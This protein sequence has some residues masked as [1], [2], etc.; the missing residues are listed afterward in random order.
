[1]NAQRS[2]IISCTTTKNRI[3]LLFYMIESL[4]KQAL[5]PDMV[6]VNISSAPSLA[7]EGIARL[8]AWLDKEF[9]KI[10]RVKDMGPYTKLLPVIEMVED[11]D[12]IVTADDDILYHPTWLQ[13]LVE[14]ADT[15]PDHIICARA[16]NIKKNIFGKWQGY[17]NW[18]RI[19]RTKEGMSILPTG[20]GGVVYR[21]ALLD[22]EFLMDLTAQDIAPTTDDLWFRMASLRKKV[23]VYVCPEID[24]KSIYLKHNKGL[25]QINFNRKKNSYYRDNKKNNPIKKMRAWIGIKTTRNDK[26]WSRIN[27][28]S[29]SQHGSQ[30]R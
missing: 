6:Y 4:K 30:G 23:P 8:P 10:N 19:C 14:L 11:N 12:L 7:T 15:H 2:I 25:E 1:M 24:Q 9:I 27:R 28:F 21:K 22:V 20:A 13:S 3:E 26:A 5:M 17:Y 16:R 18:D 29:C